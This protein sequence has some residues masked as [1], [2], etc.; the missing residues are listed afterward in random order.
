[1]VGGGAGQ[2]NATLSYHGAESGISASKLCGLNFVISGQGWGE[3]N[4]RGGARE[5]ERERT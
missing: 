1:M 2:F 4:G 3:V 5:R